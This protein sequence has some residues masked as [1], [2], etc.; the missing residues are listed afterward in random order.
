MDFW[1]DKYRIN[2]EVDGPEH[3][4]GIHPELDKRRD[5]WLLKEGWLVFRIPTDGVKRLS[6]KT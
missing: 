6:V 1:N 2:I 3:R 4:I 5:R